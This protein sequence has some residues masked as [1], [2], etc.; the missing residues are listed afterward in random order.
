MAHGLPSLHPMIRVALSLLPI[1]GLV[2]ATSC[3]SS[4]TAGRTA[5]A[6]ASASAAATAP[7][8]RVVAP[9]LVC[10]VN[11]RFMGSAQIPTEV[12]GRT[13]YG[14]C[15]MCSGKLRSEPNMRTAK[16]P[17]SGEQ[18]DK[19]TAVIAATQ[20]GDVLYFKN[21]GTLA[22]YRPAKESP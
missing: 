1:A 14:C 20:G 19:A 2:L 5:V 22:A 15:P 18:V 6:S 4:N 17:V 10:M 12:E 3:R 16:D 13:Y 21:E 8:L 7:G 11:N 9:N